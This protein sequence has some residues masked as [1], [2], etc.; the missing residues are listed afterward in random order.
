[1]RPIAYVATT[2]FGHLCLSLR[3]A[4]TSILL[5]IGLIGIMF[6][7]M[8]SLLLSFAT[9]SPTIVMIPLISSPLALSGFS[10]L[11]SVKAS[12]C[13]MASSIVL[14]YLH[15]NSILALFFIPFMKWNNIYSSVRLG[16]SCVNVVNYISYVCMLPDNFSSH[17]L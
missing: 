15:S 10:C 7:R 4:M 1:M 6:L 12:A 5:A 9:I 2:S 13:V 14:S 16:I 3:V 17:I 8:W 11:K